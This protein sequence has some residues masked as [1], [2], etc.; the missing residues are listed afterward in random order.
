[1]TTK[2]AGPGLPK[3]LRAYIPLVAAGGMALLMYLNMG[4]EWD[5]ST[6]AEVGLFVV[7]IIAAGS[8]PLPVGQGVKTDVSTAI[9]FAAAIVLEPG[10]AALAGTVGLVTYT[11]LIRFWGMKLRLPWYKYP[12]NAGQTAL[13]MGLTSLVFHGLSTGDAVL[14]A[15]AVP[16]AVTYYLVNTTLVSCAAGLHMQVNPINVWR[17]GTRENGLAEVAF[18]AFG[19]LGG[20][21]YQESPWTI[22]ALSVPIGVIYIAFFRL[23]QKISERER[24]KEELEIRVQARTSELSITGS[25]SYMHAQEQLRKAVAAQLHGPV[26]NRLLVASHWLHTAQES[27][28]LDMAKSAEHLANAAHLIEEINQG[29]LRAAMSR[30]HPSLIR[31]SLL[32]SLRSLSD[33]FHN[34][35][36]VDVQASGQEAD[37]EEL[38]RSG[39]PEELR[40]AIYR[41]VEEAL[42]NVLKHSEATRVELKLDTPTKDSV[43]LAVRDNGRGFEPKTTTLGFGIV[44]MQD[45]CGA[46]GG[47]IDVQSE[48]GKGT[49]IVATFPLAK[50]SGGALVHS[51]SNGTG[52]GHHNGNGNGHHSGNGNGN[53]HQLEK[54]GIGATTSDPGWSWAQ[55]EATTLLIVDDQVDFCGLVRELL[56]PYQEFRVLGEANDGLTSL[57]LV[58]DL[59]P[60]VVLLDVEMPGLHGLET[61]YEI[62]TRF[63]EV[64]IV[65]MS[66][67]HQKQYMNEALPPGV[68]DFIPK[69]EFSVNRLREACKNAPAHIQEEALEQEPAMAGGR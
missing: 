41:V 52:N 17:S 12:F 23:A 32:A 57:G 18:F 68:S 66:G 50:A 43:T 29:D 15:A 42:N 58:E 62:H 64:R 49:A 27:M 5:A 48:V 67:Y 45:Y 26:Q 3:P 44:S 4:M 36:Q 9:L 38:W 1:M 16:A 6:L 37:S 33:Q 7:L 11:A 13:F 55:E 54:N 65:L 35:F 59:Q 19:F 10:A 53:G 21:L 2:E 20:I 61:A 56:R 40:L 47:V 46:V 63:P 31:V 34:S 69:A 8:F 24:A 39:M 25:A 28:P 30:L 14:S 60:D 22:V 51:F